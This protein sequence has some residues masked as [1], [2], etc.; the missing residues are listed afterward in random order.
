MKDTKERGMLSWIMRKDD[1]EK[2]KFDKDMER[3]HDLISGQWL[4]QC[5][6]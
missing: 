4:H 6:D 1:F 2:E 3:V 5:T